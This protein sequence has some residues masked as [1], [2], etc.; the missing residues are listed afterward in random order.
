MATRRIKMKTNPYFMVRWIGFFC[1]FNIITVLFISSQDDGAKQ[2]TGLH[3]PGEYSISLSAFVNTQQSSSMPSS[4]YIYLEDTLSLPILIDF[5]TDVIK[6]FPDPPPSSSIIKYVWHRFDVDG[7]Y[8]DFFSY[9]RDTSFIYIFSG[10]TFVKNAQVPR[11]ISF[12]KPAQY[13]PVVELSYKVWLPYDIYVFGN[14]SIYVNKPPDSTI[15]NS[16]DTLLLVKDDTISALVSMGVDVS[17]NSFGSIPTMYCAV[18]NGLK[19]DGTPYSNKPGTHGI[20]DV[21]MSKPVD[22]NRSSDDSIYFSFYFGRCGYGDMPESEDSLFLDFYSPVTGNWFRVW[23]AGGGSCDNTM[24]QVLIPIT[25]PLFLQKGFRFRFYNTASLYGPFDYWF[26]DYIYIDTLRNYQDFY[27]ED[28]AFAGQL[29]YVFKNYRTVPFNHY[30]QNPLWFMKDTTNLQISNLA[31]FDRFVQSSYIVEDVD[32]NSVVYQSAVVNHPVVPANSYYSILFDNT[33]WTFPTSGTYPRKFLIKYI[34]TSTPDILRSND[35]LKIPYTLDTYYAYDDGLPEKAYTVYGNQSSVAIKFEVPVVDT[36]R[37]IW[38]YL[39]PL[40]NNGNM[41][42]QGVV[43]SNLNPSTILATT[44][45]IL[46]TG[47]WQKLTLSPPVPVSGT[48]YAGYKNLD[49]GPIYVGMDMNKNSQQLTFY[50]A[51]NGWSQTSYSGALMIRIDFGNSTTLTPPDIPLPPADEC[52]SIVQ[53]S[54]EKI[55]IKTDKAIQNGV[56]ILYDAT[57]KQVIKSIIQ[58]SEL[59]LQRGNL[60]DGYYTGLLLPSSCSR[61]ILLIK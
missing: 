41:R 51:G 22:L 55:L 1:C 23:S 52:F 25:D 61:K 20:A 16:T 40:V 33:G 50:N 35:T 48:L 30:I 10:G 26:I 54:S 28:V 58:G 57:G 6:R 11:T 53:L 15:Y 17:F 9:L 29:D 27:P 31:S 47:G 43:W 49:Y 18:F 42:L 34:I 8:P 7:Y 32:N 45:V 46:N 3:P 12:Y 14:D 39:P 19:S 44:D 38:I 5:S 4:N 2:K 56:F 13:P 21:L 36:L 37:S 59:S 60:K 24:S